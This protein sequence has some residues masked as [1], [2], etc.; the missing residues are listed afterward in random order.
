MIRQK[1]SFSGDFNALG[2]DHGDLLR[3]LPRSSAKS[4]RPWPRIPLNQS[5]TVILTI[6]ADDG[7]SSRSNS[8]TMVEVTSINGAPAALTSRTATWPATSR[9]R[10]IPR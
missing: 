4:A 6:T 1:G 9:W 2:H 3:R 8:L 10:T 5:E 7:T